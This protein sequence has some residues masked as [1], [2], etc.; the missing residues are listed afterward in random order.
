MERKGFWAYF[1]T[2]GDL[3][4][5]VQESNDHYSW[6][7]KNSK[8]GEEIAHGEAVHLEDAMVA[9]AQAAGAEWGAI[10]WSSA[11]RNDEG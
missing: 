5:T 6:G 3:E 8:T 4:L 2:L 10:R 7:V 1:A 9:A 11:E